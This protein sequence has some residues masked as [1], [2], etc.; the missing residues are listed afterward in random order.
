[1]AEADDREVY[2]VVVHVGADALTPAPAAPSPAGV[3]AETQAP[4]Q[5]ATPGDPDGTIED[6]HDADITEDTIIPP[7]Y[8][9]RLDLDH[10]IYTC[11]ANARAEQ[12]RRARRDQA[13]EPG[14]QGRVQV[15]EPEGW[16][17][18]IR[19]Y[20]DEHAAKPRG[21]VLVPIPA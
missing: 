20:Y 21:P 3:S 16:A 15:F 1:V 4:A 18:R 9:E 13:G 17:D 12:E 19:R 8:G 14:A 10:A 11:L 2:Q 7:W 6:C 5:P